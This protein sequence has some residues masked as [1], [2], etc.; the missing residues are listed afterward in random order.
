MTGAKFGIQFEDGTWG[1]FNCF[2]KE[3]PYEDRFTCQAC[4]TIERRNA[5]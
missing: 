5:Q 2:K 3:V 1:C 4:R